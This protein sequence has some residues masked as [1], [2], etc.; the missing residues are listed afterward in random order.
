M[1]RGCMDN[2]FGEAWTYPNCR[3]ECCHRND[4]V[5]TET[6]VY[7][8]NRRIC[9]GAL[10][11]STAATLPARSPFAHITC[12]ITLLY[13]GASR[14]LGQLQ[15]ISS[16]TEVVALGFQRCIPRYGSYGSLSILHM[17][18][19]DERIRKRISSRKLNPASLAQN[20]S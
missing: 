4:P 6:H 14:P 11:T 9:S 10:R 20:L 2:N 19:S 7:C 8:S 12:W 18:L 17:S 16:R 13:Q 1:P 15:P 3:R 5:S